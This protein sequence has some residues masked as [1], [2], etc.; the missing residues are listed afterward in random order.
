MARGPYRATGV[1][2]RE[3]NSPPLARDNGPDPLAQC[4]SVGGIKSAI[5]TLAE[6][7]TRCF[8]FQSFNLLQVSSTMPAHSLYWVGDRH[9]SLDLWVECRLGKIGNPQSSQQT[10]VV[11]PCQPVERDEFRGK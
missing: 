5:D 10:Q 6:T 1:R 3:L 8:G 9:V 11:M 4:H 2:P 7:T